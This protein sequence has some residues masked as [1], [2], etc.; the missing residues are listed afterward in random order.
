MVTAT[1]TIAEEIKSLLAQFPQNKEQLIAD[2]SFSVFCFGKVTH[3]FA[4]GSHISEGV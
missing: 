3:T 2:N 4:D 1:I